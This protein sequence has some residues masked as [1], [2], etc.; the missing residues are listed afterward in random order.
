MYSSKEST[1]AKNKKKGHFE[2]L[3]RVVAAGFDQ[4]SEHV[5]TLGK[6]YKNGGVFILSKTE[7]ESI[8]SGMKNLKCTA[9]VKFHHMLAYQMEL[10]Y[11][12]ALSLDDV[13]SPNLGFES[14]PGV[15]SSNE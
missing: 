13:V 12:L 9:K 6:D 14:V 8:R 3:L 4:K 15:L 2:S 11:A 10:G 5:D 1:R 7:D